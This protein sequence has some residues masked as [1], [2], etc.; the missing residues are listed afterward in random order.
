METT[1]NYRGIEFDVEY[2]YTPEEKGDR[3][4]PGCPADIEIWKIEFEGKDFYDF[5]D[6]DMYVDVQNLILKQV[7]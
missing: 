3:D 2:T 4:Y 1:I 6:F 7:L 5:F